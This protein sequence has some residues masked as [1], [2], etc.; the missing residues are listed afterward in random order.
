MANVEI[1]LPVGGC[2]PSAP[3]NSMPG[4]GPNY[5]AGADL[6]LAD[7]LSIVR[8]NDAI[9]NGYR[10]YGT[11]G[12][13]D[14]V[15]ERILP[16]VAAHLNCVKCDPAA[17]VEAVCPNDAVMYFNAEHCY[18]VFDVWCYAGILYLSKFYERHSLLNETGSLFLNQVLYPW[19]IMNMLRGGVKVTACGINII[20]PCLDDENFYYF[21]HAM[22]LAFNSNLMKLHKQAAFSDLVIH[23]GPSR[24]EGEDGAIFRP[25]SD[26]H[27]TT[28]EAELTDPAGM[29]PIMLRFTGSD[30]FYIGYQKVENPLTRTHIAS[31]DVRNTELW[32]GYMSILSSLLYLRAST[33]PCPSKYFGEVFA[34][35]KYP[36][37]PVNLMNHLI[38]RC[39][40]TSRCNTVCPT[41]DITVR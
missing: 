33:M 10:F 24:V 34:A 20:G 38:E 39:E 30:R 4:S 23:S 22:R 17:I 21:R 12:R 26:R 36:A 13:N 9:S 5:D 18:C 16:Y 29:L 28:A 2:I 1:N 14:R 41:C 19:A 15:V 37:I 3:E 11:G 27:S 8:Y 32:S 7:A 25:A 6:A 40:K 31:D 35:G